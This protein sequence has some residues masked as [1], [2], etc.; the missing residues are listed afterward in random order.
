M[1]RTAIIPVMLLLALSSCT[2]AAPIT[3]TQAIGTGT[4]AP[5]SP[6]SQT[7]STQSPVTDFD[8]E[9][10]PLFHVSVLPVLEEGQGLE[11]PG[12]WMA[13]S[14][15]E[16]IVLVSQ[17]GK[18]SGLIPLDLKHNAR[19][20][21]APGGGNLAF[22]DRRAN[23]IS[24]EIRSIA[25]NIP[26]LQLSLLGYPGTSQDLQPEDPGFYALD[27]LH[28]AV[29][30]M[31]WSQQ[32]T[33]LAFTAAIDGPTSDVYVYDLRTE[34]IT[35]LTDE[36]SQAV[37]LNWSPD[38]RFLL[39][40]EVEDLYEG[41]NGSGYSG[42]VFHAVRLEDGDVQQLSGSTGERVE[43]HV[44]GWF[45]NTNV[46][47]AAREWSPGYFNIR[48]LNIETGEEILLSD[49]HFN[50]LAY[51][52]DNQYMLGCVTPD[53]L[54]RDPSDLEIESGFYNLSAVDG[55]MEAIQNLPND[56]I[57]YSMSFEPGAKV[58][59]MEVES[60]GAVYDGELLELMEAPPLFSPDG[61]WAVLCHERCSTLVIED[62]ELGVQYT[63][64]PEGLFMNPT[65]SPDSS[66][67]FY[68]AL[69]F[70]KH[71]D[72]LHRLDPAERSM[73]IVLT[74]RSDSIR[75]TGF[76]INP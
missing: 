43:Q 26:L 29:G 3:A 38:S 7:L 6:H 11:N 63:I 41:A 48:R 45:D 28:A 5:T 61:R 71:K 37:F 65:W 31:A 44:L 64:E 19:N 55:Q 56:L 58:F 23:A 10:I 69:N 59:V 36:P 20:I 75:S 51:D 18:E 60:G 14:V 33:M 67:L 27:N 30:Q 57:V 47:L 12:P 35:R 32:G 8:P 49:H 25:N 40:A 4:P 54:F 39:H 24:L 13:L 1:Y 46:I 73:E 16:G 17:D 52:P 72:E 66:A 68:T 53:P 34:E 62:V 15:E 9:E 2:P 76:W 50:S 42:W 21:P 70:D 74:G 22:L